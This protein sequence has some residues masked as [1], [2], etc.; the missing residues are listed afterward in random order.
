M[1]G[2]QKEIWDDLLTDDN[3]YEMEYYLRLFD[4]LSDPTRFAILY[5]LHT[6]GEMSIEELETATEVPEQDLREELM[7]L[8]EADIIQSWKK[9]DSDKGSTYWNY[10]ISGFGSALIRSFESFLEQEREAA[11]YFRD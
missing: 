8:Q 10:R 1:T 4:L 5:V 3:S 7:K 2:N 9:S 11:E 6:D